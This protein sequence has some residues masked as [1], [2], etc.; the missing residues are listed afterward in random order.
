MTLP[1]MKDELYKWI[2]ACPVNN[3]VYEDE[4]GTVVIEIKDDDRD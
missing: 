1:R 2:E 3:F 4:D